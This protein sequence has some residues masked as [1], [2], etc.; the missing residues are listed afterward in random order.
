TYC[1]HKSWGFGRVASVNFLLNQMTIDF[2]AKKSHTMQLQYAA[3]SLQPLPVGHI[4]ERKATDLASV[5]AL[6]KDDPIALVRIILESHGGKATQDQV[7]QSLAPD[8]FNEVEF[9][10]WWESAKKLLKKDGHFS[11][12]TKKSDPIELRAAP[13]SRGED[14]LAAFF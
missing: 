4:L 6:A 7:A 5:K 11:V 2:H 8:V 10:R 14:L 13:V 9:K 12:P 1:V 3:E